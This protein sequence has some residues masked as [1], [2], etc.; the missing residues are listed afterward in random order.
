M[1]DIYVW[2]AALFLLPFLDRWEVSRRYC[3]VPVEIDLYPMST[4]YDLLRLG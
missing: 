3:T 4:A 2:T 1:V